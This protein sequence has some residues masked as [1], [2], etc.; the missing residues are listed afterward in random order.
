[1]I[2][3]EQKGLVALA[4]SLDGNLVQFSLGDDGDLGVQGDAKEKMLEN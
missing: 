1:M 3:R 2:S 4:V